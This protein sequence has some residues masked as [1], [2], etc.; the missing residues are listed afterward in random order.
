MVP[1]NMTRAELADFARNAATQVAAGKVTGLLPEQIVSFSNGLETDADELS[2]VDN[3]IVALRT[4]LT[5]ATERGRQIKKRTLRRSQS[6]KYSM[7]SVNSSDSEFDAVGLEPPAQRRR[8]V[9]AQTPTELSA[10]GFSNFV[11]VLRFTGN[12]L[13]NRARYLIE[14]KIGDATDYAIVGV[15]KAQK[16]KH[17]GVTP[18]VEYQ[19]R[20]YA[21]TARGQVSDFSN[22]AVVYRL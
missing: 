7:K 17:L 12:N 14:A 20:V 6:L 2:E 11:N 22:E 10:T 15:S 21:Q 18:G 5:A 19:Y 9:H 8:M 16:F 13:P 1:N 3:E 4:A